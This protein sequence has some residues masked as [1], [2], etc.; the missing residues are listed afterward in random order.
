MNLKEFRQ[1]IDKLCDSVQ[2]PEEITVA[3]PVVRM[4]AIGPCAS[5]PVKYVYQGI[6]WDSNTL[7]IQPEGD[8]LREINLDEIKALAEA[9]DIVVTEAMKKRKK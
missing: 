1:K 5:V 2:Y 6:D 9:Y 3:I 4:N 8:E 7:F